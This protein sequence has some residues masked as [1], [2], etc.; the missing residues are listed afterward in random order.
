MF[1]AKLFLI[2]AALSIG[3]FMIVLYVSTHLENKPKSNKF[4]QWWNKYITD[5]DNTY[6][7]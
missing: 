4:R 5:L 7:D 3:T 1:I 6:P 2:L